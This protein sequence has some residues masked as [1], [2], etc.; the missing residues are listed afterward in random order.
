MS[1]LSIKNLVKTYGSFTAVDGISLEIAENEIFGFLG[2]NGA[3]KTTAIKMIC[4]LISKTS[5]SVKIF[6]E[7]VS[8]DSSILK[9]IGMAPQSAVFWEKLTCTEQLEYLGGLYGIQKKVCRERAEKLLTD[10][11]LIEKRKSLG[12][13]LSG[14]MQRRLNLALALIHDPELIV[15]DE[16]EAGLDPQS[17]ILVREYIRSLSGTKTILL[18]THDMDEADRLSGRIAIIDQGKLLKLGTPSDLKKDF[19]RDVSLEDVFIGLTGR[20]LR[21]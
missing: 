16:P 3:G 4:G 2:P 5:G 19:G 17:R 12:G 8:S 10:L 18:T 11:G 15:L 1:A 9:R 20:R 21:E 7:E 6:G 14:G 13:T